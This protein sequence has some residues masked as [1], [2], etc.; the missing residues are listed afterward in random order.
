MKRAWSLYVSERNKITRGNAVW[1]AMTIEE[2]NATFL[3]L[4]RAR[5]LL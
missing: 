3:E 4:A 2:L 5:G 1:S